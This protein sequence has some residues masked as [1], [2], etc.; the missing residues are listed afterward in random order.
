MIKGDGTD[1]FGDV[2]GDEVFLDFMLLSEDMTPQ[3]LDLMDDSGFRIYKGAGD[4]VTLS[5]LPP[6]YTDDPD[7][8]VVIVGSK[9]D[10]SSVSG[11]RYYLAVYASDDRND[12]TGQNE[13]L[14]P[15]VVGSVND[16]PSIAFLPEIVMDEDHSYLA[17]FDFKQEYISDVDTPMEELT[18]AVTSEEPGLEFS[19]VEGK[20]QIV[21]VE[22]YNGI[23]YAKVTVS[24]GEAE[25]A[26]MFRVIVKSINDIPTLTI[27]N[28]YDGMMIDDLLLV[29]GTAEDS[30]KNLKSV[31]VAVVEEGAMV[32]SDDWEEASGSY[33]WNYMFDIRN[34][35]DG[36]YEIHVRAYDGNRDFSEEYVANVLVKNP[37]QKVDL[38]PPEVSITTELSGDWTDSVEVEGTLSDDS[39]YVSFVEY[40][41]DTGGWKKA[42]IDQM[43][44]WSA[45]V[46]TRMLENEE[47]MFSVRAYDGKAYSEEEMMTFEVMNEDSDLDGVKNEDERVYAMDPFNPID[48]TMDYD[49]DGYSNVVEI[50]AGTDI[51][52]AS[53]HPKDVGADE[54][55][56]EPWA[57]VMVVAA[58]LFAI[59]IMG[60]FVMN[61]RMDRKIHSFREELSNR[62]AVKRPKTLLQKIVDIAPSYKP[63]VVPLS[64][65]ALGTQ[66][67]QD[68][69][70]PAPDNLNK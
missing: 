3:R 39:G 29:R 31:Q 59:L 64:G 56:I 6:E 63:K 24:D 54:N 23:A 69:L 15:I 34:Y 43:A 2:E 26:S 47:H 4:E 8:Y 1:Y 18:V 32:S 11:G 14:I 66:V 20:L 19:F 13:V 36:A 58:V 62:R 65:P 40:R 45:I 49:D 37:K 70:P 38:T 41:I 60:L 9:G 44:T 10:Y 33:L 55:R 52:D 35:E 21:P 46:N 27:K 22:D 7:N 30:E 42:T 57:I 53:D 17:S 50:D 25:A 48:G 5:V 61:L 51:F 12:P 16:E 28:V 67:Q 68:N